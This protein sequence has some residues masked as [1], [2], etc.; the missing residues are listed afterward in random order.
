MIDYC[1]IVVLPNG[2]RDYRIQYTIKA[3]KKYILKLHVILI[4]C[5]VEQ[6]QMHEVRVALNCELIQRQ[7]KIICDN[8]LIKSLS[9]D[10]SCMY[11]VLFLLWY[12]RSTRFHHSVNFRNF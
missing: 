11:I 12:T 5:M 4:F 8:F 1:E 2:V 3:T 9:M 6:Y 10:S 7:Y